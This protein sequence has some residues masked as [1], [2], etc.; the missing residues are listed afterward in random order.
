MGMSVY[1]PKCGCNGATYWNGPVAITANEPIHHEGACT[2]G[3]GMPCTETANACSQ[4][5]GYCNLG[6]PMGAMCNLALAGS[7]WVLPSS[8]SGTPGAGVACG[9]ATCRTA[10]DLIEAQKPWVEMNCTP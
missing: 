3:E 4:V 8:C 1:A 5:A 7:C 9:D 6:A 2:I 10:C